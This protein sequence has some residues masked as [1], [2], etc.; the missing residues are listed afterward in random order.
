M[1]N[2]KLLSIA[3]A[4][5]SVSAANAVLVIDRGLPTANLNNIS[6]ANRSNVSWGFGQNPEDYFTGDDFTLGST[7]D[8]NNPI[9]KVN[10]ITT[11]ATSGPNGDANFFLGDRYTN[12]RLY[13]GG[14]SGIGVISS[15]NFSIGQSNTDNANITITKVTYQNGDGYQVPNNNYVQ[16][17]KVEFSNLNLIVNPGDL[18]QFGVTGAARDQNS[19]NTWFNH[20]SNAALSGSTQDGSDDLYRY[21]TVNDLISGSGAWTSAGNGWDKASDVNVLVDAE[22]VPEPV[23]LVLAGALL[24]LLA[25]RRKK[26]I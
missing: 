25:K 24:P 15:G 23:T 10:K 18:T 20:A 16:L 26:S 12:V 13:A 6:G 22:A 11:W 14:L 19:G 2:Y 1:K 7:G 21:H 3:F 9:W 5:L 17:W 4:M 8:A